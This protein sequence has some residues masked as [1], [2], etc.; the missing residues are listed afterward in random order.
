MEQVKGF[1]SKPLAI[2]ISMV[3]ILIGSF[4][5]YQV[6]TDGG[7]M[8]ISDLRFT[9][10]DGIVHSAQM[11]KPANFNPE[12]E[13]PTIV[14]THGYINSREAQAPFSIELAKRGYVVLTMDMTGHGYSEQFASDLSRGMTSGLL[15]AHN[16]PFVDNDQVGLAGHSMGGWSA[17]HAATTNPDLVNSVFQISSSTETFGSGEV[18]ADTA[19]NY[20]ILFSEYDEFA[21]T[22]WGVPKA[23]DVNTSE[24]MLKVFGVDEPVEQE[25]VY[26]SFD[27]Q[28]ARV[29]YAPPV[30]HPGTHWSNESI[31]HVIEFMDQAMPAPTP[32]DASDQSWKAKEL[33]TLVALIGAIMLLIALLGNL[34]RA[35]FF[36]SLVRSMPESKAEPTM[37]GWI[38]GALIATIIPAATFIYFQEL[39]QGWLPA[40]EVLRQNITTG[41]A[42]WAILNAVIAAALLTIFHFRNKNNGGT[43]QNYGLILDGKSLGKS[44]V[45]ALTV[46]GL[47][48]VTVSAAALF[49]GIDF[50]IWVMAFKPM[51][52]TQ[53]G[54]VLTYFIPFLIF[55]LVNGVILHGQLRLKDSSSEKKTFWKWFSANFAINALG[56]V[57]LLV[58]QYVTLFS[59]GELLWAKPLLTIVAYQFVFVNLIVAFVSTFLFRKT[60]TIYA[61]AL[62]NAFLITWYIVAGQAMQI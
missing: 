41:L 32:I 46:V 58:I 24:K 6:Q 36:S 14:N 53:F 43:M 39:G 45:Y 21:L 1:F 40:G 8:E 18:T 37:I 61:A 57:G 55:F 13:Y 31:G 26:G 25:V 35:P 42:V 23:S 7:E 28:S 16:L 50:R 44:V 33:S 27:D 47:L 30:I 60:G 12:E 19:F 52:L 5:A 17:L 3:I 34:L 20:G 11:Y 49:F 38:I 15:Y 10:E 48:Y 29:F 22:M 9:G 4:V 51:S 62:V 59:T 54:L 56:I 2:I